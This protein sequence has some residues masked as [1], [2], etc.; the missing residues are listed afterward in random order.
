M[1]VGRLRVTGC[2]RDGARKEDGGQGSQVWGGP[3]VPASQELG[4]RRC[5]EK[6]QPLLVVPG[7]VPIWK[8]MLSKSSLLLP[9]AW[10]SGSQV[11]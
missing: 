9:E 2:H 1:G 3:E 6:H 5:H 10:I 7:K 4:N 11:N 8:G